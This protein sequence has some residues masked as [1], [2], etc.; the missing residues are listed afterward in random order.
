[1]DGE[2]LNTIKNISLESLCIA[3]C[4]FVLTMLIKWPIKKCTAKFSEDKRKA[5]NTVILFIPIIL[6]LIG[7]IL[8]YGIFKA[9]WFKLE[10]FE[11][12]ISSW[13]VSLTIYAIFEHIVI[14]IKGIRSGKVKIDSDLTKETLTFLKSNIKTLTSKIKLDEKQVKKVKE[15]LSSLLE[16]KNIIESDETIKDIAK[17]SETNI[18]IQ[19]LK[20]E[21][22]N[23]QTKIDENQKQ[24]Q[25]YIDKLYNKKGANYGI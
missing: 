19:E 15:K 11:T 16:I 24:K 3:I 4:V 1:M 5:V 9:S 12:A 14:L 22:K 10:V 17:L 8:Y 23:L 6:A 21:E 20:N 18:Q 25:T 13:I 2:I 7:S